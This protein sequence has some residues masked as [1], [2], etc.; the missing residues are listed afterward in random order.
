MISRSEIY[1]F[2]SAHRLAVVSSVSPHGAPES[3]L[4]YMV[5]TPELEL[6]FYTLQTARKCENLRRDG[7]ISLVIGW[8]QENERIAQ[9][10]TVQYEGI[11][12]EQLDDARDKAKAVYLAGLPENAGMATWPG[13]TFFRVTPTWIRFSSYGKPWRVEELRFE[14][15][16]RVHH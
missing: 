11:A 7:R 10:D 4:I 6:V 14:G 9:Q 12:K 3:A 8:P 13:L 16:Q 5:P 1:E 2:L 15:A